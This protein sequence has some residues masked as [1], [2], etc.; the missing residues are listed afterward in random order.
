ME[1]VR[2][3]TSEPESEWVDMEPRG[4]VE[5]GEER[6]LHAIF[7]DRQPPRAR[8]DRMRDLFTSRV[9]PD[10]SPPAHPALPS[11][12]R[13]VRTRSPEREEQS[14]G[15]D[16]KL[17]IETDDSIERQ[18]SLETQR[19]LSAL[20]R[21]LF[22]RERAVSPYSPPQH[23]SCPDFSYE[24]MRQK[25]GRVGDDEEFEDLDVDK[26]CSRIL[27]DGGYYLTID[28]SHPLKGEPKVV[29]EVLKSNPGLFFSIPSHLQVDSQLQKIAFVAARKAHREDLCQDLIVHCSAQGSTSLLEFER[30]ISDLCFESAGTLA[31]FFSEHP[32]AREDR[33]LVLSLL[34]IGE[35]I[36]PHIGPQI[37][38]D[39]PFLILA[40]EFGCL[41]LQHIDP[42]IQ[43][44]K[45][46]VFAI[47]RRNP[48]EL[49]HASS[50]YQ[51]DREFLCRVA[52]CNGMILAFVQM[53]QRNDP[54]LVWL[55]LH[56]NGLAL[57]HAPAPF[58]ND[59]RMVLAAITQ[60]P[61]ALQQASL[62][63]RDDKDVV[64]KVLSFGMDGLEFASLRIQRSMQTPRDF[65][66]ATSPLPRLKKKNGHHR[67]RG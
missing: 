65:M 64:Q 34:A 62:Q 43:Q 50:A 23:S 12:L 63:L 59:K 58:R 38:C 49:C 11:L 54:E 41:I 51:E 7:A 53:A 45:E 37:K 48:A 67:I 31:T 13:T 1:P 24:L 55:A 36:F 17:E 33:E 39:K 56:Q 32:S 57:E 18:F 60:N 28:P 20:E 2:A 5:S 26:M 66:P 10:R 30:S 25:R 14:E 46:L 16:G 19:P 42:V 44:D 9:S 3:R 8:E 52:K 15:E 4:A 6:E 47:V 29:K 35:D 21:I 22:E 27:K 61:R 40:S